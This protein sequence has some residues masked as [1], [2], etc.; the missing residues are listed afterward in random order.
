MTASSNSEHLLD[1]LLRCDKLKGVM[2][3]K[4]IRGAMDPANYVGGAPQ[5][6]DD[7]V[8]AVEKALKKK[9]T[10]KK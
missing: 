2:S 3:E 10:G 5:I 1:V 8:A 7:M 6:V 9:I 4:D